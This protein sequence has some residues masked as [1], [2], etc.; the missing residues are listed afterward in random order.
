MTWWMRWRAD[1]ARS[2]TSVDHRELPFLVAVTAVIVTATQVTD[3]GT[4]VDLLLVIA[5]AAA[6]VLSAAS[7]R[8][9]WVLVAVAVSVLLAAAMWR[10]GS[11]EIAFFVGVLATLYAA[12]HLGSLTKA[13]VCTAVAAIAPLVVSIALPEEEIAWT[14]WAA[15]NVLMLAVGRNV[16][17]QRALI[18]QLEAAREALAD[19]AV[20][21]E[22]QRIARELHDLAGHTL[23]TVLLHVTGAR[24]VL[25]RDPDE[26]ERAL[27]Q[28][29]AVGRGSL[30]Q[31]R[32][33][34]ASLRT[35][36][37]GTDPPL[38]GAADLLGLVE[39]YR[40]A[41][42]EVTSVVA[43]TA[44]SIEGP[45]G[46]ALHRIGREALANVARHAPG[47]RVELALDL[48]SDADEVRLVVADH[49]RVAAYPQ[50]DDGH[51]GLM[52]MR[53]RARALGG[54]LDAGPTVDGWQ[55]EVRLPL[56]ATG[57]EGLG[58]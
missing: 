39:E 55:V 15:A 35:S 42:L 25:R 30:D 20:A 52:G 50:P 18:D 53:E 1:L 9:R 19:Q 45:V 49:G 54:D 28:A 3:P 13:V 38:A 22:R 57:R 31:I 14:P 36:E 5:A 47:N 43:S 33:T 48:D 6:L 41:G 4:P 2:D 11:L 24:H 40:L 58:P 23:A 51:F 32:S 27:L 12:W 26:A 8:T 56:S 34:V 7:R 16:R 37:R 17:R 46:T 29:E 21:E 10:E 44:A